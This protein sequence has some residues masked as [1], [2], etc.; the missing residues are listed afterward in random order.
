MTED[1]VI[2]PVYDEKNRPVNIKRYKLLGHQVAF[3]KDK[4]KQEVGGVSLAEK[5]REYCCT[6]VVI[7]IGPMVGTPEDNKAKRSLHGWS[8]HSWISG[9]KVGM[10]VLLPDGCD[11]IS[12]PFPADYEGVIHCNDILAI[13]EGLE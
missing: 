3:C 5:T 12:H 13:V 10:R 1:T 2:V 7:G 9:L 11:T 4:F 6:A 8:K